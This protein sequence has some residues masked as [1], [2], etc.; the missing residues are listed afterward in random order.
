MTSIFEFVPN[1]KHRQFVFF[2]LRISAKNA[3]WST[4][5]FSMF[6]HSDSS[7]Y[8]MLLNIWSHASLRTALEFATRP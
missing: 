6:D 2:S 1:S 4:L 3:E 5:F 7:A 8:E